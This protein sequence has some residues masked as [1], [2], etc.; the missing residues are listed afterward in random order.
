MV[1]GFGTTG[2]FSVTLRLAV[3]EY[4]IV[5]ECGQW[6]ANNGPYEKET[7]D[8]WFD[9]LYD[10]CMREKPNENSR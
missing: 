8:T 10:L 4:W 2:L 3:N 1:K 5:I 7:A 6:K 9:F